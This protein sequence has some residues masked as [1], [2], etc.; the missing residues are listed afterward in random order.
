MIGEFFID[1]GFGIL[2]SALEKL[3][4]MTWTVETSAGEFLGDFLD[5]VC[6]LLPLGTIQ[7]IFSL[8]MTLT[9]MRIGI[10]FIRTIWGFIPFV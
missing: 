9:F 4:V 6:Y 1:C 7:Q 10:A 3:P 5:M 2:S 8:I